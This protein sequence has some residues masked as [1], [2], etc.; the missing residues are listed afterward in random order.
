MENILDSSII[1]III[2]AIIRL[3]PEFIII[4]EKI[5]DN[6]HELN[7]LKE[8][9]KI[10]DN[11]YSSS[12]EMSSS[13]EVDMKYIDTIAKIQNTKTGYK[14]VDVIRALVRP[15][16][17]Y[18]LLFLYI[19]IKFIYIFNHPN[20]TLN[21]IYTLNDLS[22]LSGIM[23]YWFLNRTIQYIKGK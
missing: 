4:V 11:Q 13:Q 22:L 19:S 6:K 9:N 7:M 21:E 2:G 20:A 18:S 16:S 5:I 3:M 8:S 14:F 1:G 10:T 23:S 15:I 12:F 17:T